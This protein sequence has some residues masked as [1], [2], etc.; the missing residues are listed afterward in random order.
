MNK[1]EIKQNNIKTVYIHVCH[2]APNGSVYGTI[3]YKKRGKIFH[4]TAQFI[5]YNP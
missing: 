1:F 5:I 2:N 3:T 4:R